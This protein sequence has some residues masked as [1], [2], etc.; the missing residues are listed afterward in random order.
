MTLGC[1]KMARL[2]LRVYLSLIVVQIAIEVLLRVLGWEH[3]V[4]ENIAWLMWMLIVLAGFCA[5]LAN[6]SIPKA[7]LVA[8]PFTL[9]SFAHGLLA[10]A[11]GWP[12]MPS[13]STPVPE[14]VILSG[15][16]VASG[17]LAV[18]GVLS[19]ALAAVGARM[20]LRA[21]GVRESAA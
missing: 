10:F 16:L 3:P 20:Y 7:A 5:G 18:V 1:L 6:W 2:F 17:F 8:L 12:A 14:S 4:S 9:I 15:F 13:I 21:R 11:F 19:A